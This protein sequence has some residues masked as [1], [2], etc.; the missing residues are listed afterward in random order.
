[1]TIQEK[2]H[3]KWIETEHA[4]KLYLGIN[5]IGVINKSEH[6]FTWTGVLWL[7]YVT[8]PYLSLYARDKEALKSNL[9][10]AAI[11]WF[12]SCGI[13]VSYGE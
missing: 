12:R 9:E 4:Y 13:D 10:Y 2:L 1:M 7:P 8:A 6:S 3:F 5:Q 11:E